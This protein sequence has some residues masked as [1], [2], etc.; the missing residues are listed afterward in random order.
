M[1][2]LEH[3]GRM[4]DS[5]HAAKQLH[6][7]E[8]DEEE[9]EEKHHERRSTGDIGVDQQIPT[10]PEDDHRMSL[11]GEDAGH[12]EKLNYK[13]KSM[14]ESVSHSAGGAEETDVRSLRRKSSSQD[15]AQI[16][17]QDFRQEQKRSSPSDVERRSSAASLKPSQRLPSAAGIVVDTGEQDLDRRKSS[18]EISAIVAASSAGRRRSSNDVASLPDG[19]TSRRSVVEEASPQVTTVIHEER[20]SPTVERSEERDVVHEAE[21]KEIGVEAEDLGTVLRCL[22]LN[23]TQSQIKDLRRQFN[24][25]SKKITWSKFYP[26]VI[27]IIEEGNCK[28]ASEDELISAFS[29]L[30]VEKKGY[31]TFDQLKHFLLNMGEPLNDEE[32]EQMLHTLTIG[33]DPECFNYIEYAK[34]LAC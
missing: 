28:P 3:F 8:E 10:K 5:S 19:R 1:K 18:A 9:E 34:R 13:H 15:N 20:I 33:S 12:E 7:D 17:E 23:P 31:L 6:S 26:N 21:Q 4:G 16:G 25:D 27:S 14:D 30:D 22:N 24:G 11:R 2:E 32:F 29:Y